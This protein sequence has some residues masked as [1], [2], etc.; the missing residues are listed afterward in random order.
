MF[1][2]HND[3]FKYGLFNKAAIPP[4]GICCVAD[5]VAFRCFSWLYEAKAL[6]PITQLPL[7]CELVEPCAAA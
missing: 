3:F 6:L 4:K 7:A 5:N 1:V 2:Y